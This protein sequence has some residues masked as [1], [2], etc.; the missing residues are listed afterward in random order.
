MILKVSRRDA[1]CVSAL[2]LCPYGHKKPTAH[3]NEL[4][5]KYTC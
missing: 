5:L 2:F 1:G 3:V 4:I